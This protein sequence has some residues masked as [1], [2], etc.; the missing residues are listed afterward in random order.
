MTRLLLLLLLSVSLCTQAQKQSPAPKPPFATA[1]QLTFFKTWNWL[2]YYHPDFATGRHSADSVFFLYQP[3]IAQAKNSQQVN[4]V[5]QQLLASL[6]K[7]G[8]LAT[9]TA[10]AL[11]LLTDN[12]DTTWVARDPLLTSPVRQQLQQVY[13]HR[14]QGDKHHYL[15]ARHFDTE[16]PNEPVY[17]FA[18]T[19]NLPLAYR[20]LALA[21]LQGTVDYLFPHK[22]L[23]DKPWEQL[24]VQYMPAMIACTTRQQYETILLKLGAAFN[25]SHTWDF[26]TEMKYRKK[27]FGIQHF[28]P[29]DYTLIG[30]RILITSTIADQQCQ[31]AGIAKGDQITA[32]DGQSVTNRVNELASLL[33]ASN[34]NHLQYQL[35]LYR[36]YLLIPSSNPTIRL[37]LNRQGTTLQASLPLVQLKDTNALRQLNR[38]FSRRS[39]IPTAG[40]GLAYADSGIVYYHIYDVF[41]LIEPIADEKVFTHLDSLFAR[42][43]QSRGIIFDM[44]DY[45]DW[46]GFVYQVYRYFGQDSARYARYYTVNKANA[47]TYRYLD[48]QEVY[49]VPGIV[50][51]R[52]SYTGKVVIIVDPYTRS[53]G[54]W[55]TM[56]LQTLFPN[57]ITIGEKSSGGDG[58]RK[59]INLPGNYQFPFTGNAIF[60][61]DGTVAQRKGVRIDQPMERKVADILDEKDGFLQKAIELIKTK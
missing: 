52:K 54:E 28:L 61:P 32:I 33:S 38:Y 35:S 12:H 57:S 34:R 19:A 42:T 51:E 2:K 24:L 50:P 44:R 3:R 40:T 14:Y 27:I 6:S 25:D 58:D 5:L 15:P 16:I 45:P 43:A 21:K 59:L 49:Y 60:Y 55:N 4:Q 53:M 13:R 56:V 48:Q 17:S 30:D 18:D 47:G 46:G 9:T 11:P 41:R 22:Y 26:H 37:T 7:P 23:T 8:Q 39:N 31:Q 29:F 10:Q 1:R 36:N 20:L